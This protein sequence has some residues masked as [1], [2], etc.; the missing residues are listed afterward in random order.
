MSL[1]HRTD[2][3]VPIM[4]PTESTHPDL[5]TPTSE[6]PPHHHTQ[7][8]YNAALEDSAA[9]SILTDLAGLPTLASTS[10][11]PLSPTA[12]DALKLKA[13]SLIDTNK[14]TTKKAFRQFLEEEMAVL[15]A[16]AEVKARKRTEAVRVNEGVEEEIRR[17]EA[18]YETERRALGKRMMGK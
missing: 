18:R 7:Q 11:P 3:T 5:P 10:L 2:I 4:T 17:L 13:Q 14:F 15:V 16:E 6:T 8:P 12:L 1:A 9:S